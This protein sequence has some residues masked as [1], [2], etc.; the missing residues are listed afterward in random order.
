MG[1][2]GHVRSAKAI[3]ACVP[4]QSNQSRCKYAPILCAYI[5]TTHVLSV[6]PI[7]ARY[8]EFCA[9]FNRFLVILQK[10]EE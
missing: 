5:L 9:P 3:I 8:N 4:A 7:I 6:R 2:A 1:L 10:M